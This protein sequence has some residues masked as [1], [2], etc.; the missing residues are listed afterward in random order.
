[1]RM[2]EYKTICTC[3]TPSL[4][5]R[6]RRGWSS[7]LPPTSMSEQ[8]SA[9]YSRL[10]LSLSVLSQAR[11][12]SQPITYC[13]VIIHKTQGRILH[14]FS[15]KNYCSQNYSRIFVYCNKILCIQGRMLQYML[16]KRAWNKILFQRLLMR[17]LTLVN[18]PLK[19]GS[20]QY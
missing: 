19:N 3:F 12:I 20:S 9:V 14:Y 17:S 11:A 1:M 5:S 16:H 4:H 2:T 10:V 13:N 6:A 15:E 7:F 8:M 18:K